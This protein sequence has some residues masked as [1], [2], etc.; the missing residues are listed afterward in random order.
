PPGT[1]HIYDTLNNVALS[2]I[3]VPFASTV[4]FVPSTNLVYVSDNFYSD[5]TYVINASTNKILE[6]VPNLER[7]HG[8]AV[9]KNRSI[10]YMAYDNQQSSGIIA[11]HFNG[12]A[13]VQK[14]I[15]V[16]NGSFFD[17]LGALAV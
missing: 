15:S 9:D 1:L 17:N 2:D 7:S 5:N 16:D 12:T 8:L 13:N 10:V 14:Q 3:P 4:S 11:M 6:V